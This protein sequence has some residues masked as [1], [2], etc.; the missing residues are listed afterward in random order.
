MTG[1]SIAAVCAVGFVALA[2]FHASAAADDLTDAM[3]RAH[4][5]IISVPEVPSEHGGSV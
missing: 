3:D 4:G 5:D 1:W 2:F